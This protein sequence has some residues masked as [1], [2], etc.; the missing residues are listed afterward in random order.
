[1]VGA[2]LFLIFLVAGRTII[3]QGWW[4]IYISLAAYSLTIAALFGQTGP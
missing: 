2:I 1:V 3:N 4:W